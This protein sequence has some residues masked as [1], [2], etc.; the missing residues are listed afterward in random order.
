MHIIV[1]GLN[2]TTTPIELR[3]RLHFPTTTLEEPLEKLAHYTEGG[4][5]VILSTCNRVELYGHVQHLAHGS[6]RLQQFLSDYHGLAADALTPHLYS[7]HGEAAL[8]H[9][10]RV[11][12]SLDSLVLGEPQIAA[13]VK[14]AFAIARRASATG[15]VFNQL[16]ERAFAVAKRVRTET[17]IGEHAVSVSYAAVE[18]AKKIFQDLSAKTVLILGAGEMSELTARHLISHGVQQLL[19]ANRTPER[20]LELAERLAGQGVALADLP[21][22]LPK[23]DIVVS[24][25]GSSELVIRKADV[26]NALK[27]R[28]NRPMF[29]IDIAVPRDIDPAVNELDN[30]YV[31]DID[32]LRHVVEENRKA[33]ERE[34]AVAETIIAREVE[35]ALKWFDEQ[36]V[37]PAVIRLRRKAETIRN[38]EIEKLFARLGPL[39]DSEREAIEAMASSIINKLLHTP[40]VRLKQE[41]QARGGGRYLQALRDLFSLDE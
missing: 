35:D 8:R 5:R 15:A 11:V 40:I 14:E 10:F 12:S 19:V 17:R 28:K 9:L 34:A 38:Q 36:Q 20:A 23:A 3:E 30:V 13:Q 24:S 39:S 41:S 2:H 6:G 16:F 29:F 4:D 26:Q 27:L 21:G 31:Y 1:V 33:R 25:T 18:L 7:Y 32:D 22:Y 37:V